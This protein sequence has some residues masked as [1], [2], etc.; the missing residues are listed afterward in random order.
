M[1]DSRRATRPI[2]LFAAAG[3]F[4][5]L[6]LSLYFWR[7]R[8]F[9]VDAC[10]QSFLVIS[11]QDWAFQVQRYGAA[12]VQGPMLLLVKLG[13]PLKTVLITYSLAFTVYPLLL[14]G[15]LVGMRRERFAWALALYFL[16]LT[17]HTFFWIQSE[18]IQSTAFA[19]L[20]LAVFDQRTWRWWGRLLLLLPLILLTLY[21]HPLGV[22]PLA[23]GF[24]FLAL[25]EEV[26][27]RRG[28]ALEKRRLAWSA[29]VLVFTLAIFYVKQF[30]LGTG[31]YDVTAVDM[32][33]N[34]P[35]HLG[36]FF[37]LPAWK[38]FVDQIETTYQL[39]PP[40]LIILLVWYGRRRQWLKIACVLLGIGG[41]L[42]IILPTWHYGA[43]Q[44]YIESYYLMLA[45][46]LGLPLALDVLPN[47]RIRFALIGL[48]LVI[49]FRVGM[50][51][52]V[53]EDYIEREHY[54]RQFVEQLQELPAQRY[55]IKEEE[56]NR[57]IL[58]MNWS[59]AFETLM[60]STV[61]DPDRPRTLLPYQ[62]EVPAS[63]KEY[64]K[65]AFPGPFNPV[66]Y[67]EIKTRDYFTISDT[68]AIEDVSGRL[69]IHLPQ[70]Y[71]PHFWNA[72][73]PTRWSE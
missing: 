67:A 45:F 15:L 27:G 41:W 58:K 4:L 31:S 24:T 17:A 16:L 40:A 9:M 14:F 61:D 42:A 7:Q 26:A 59:F 53:S 30:V 11:R 33:K 2:S 10:F 72:H 36:N 57:Y 62:N 38:N 46:F 25:G 56:V 13:A 21:T 71:K 47:V 49:L 20:T 70:D 18:L 19:V 3:L 32:A 6:L 22:V 28:T 54:I 50:I 69:K 63:V 60:M 66:S 44:F 35:L 12:V 29:G 52:Q 43:E 1:D 5:L 39:M 68:T 64:E 37:D 55:V 65:T 34:I 8:V 48:G 73:E 51:L 23:F